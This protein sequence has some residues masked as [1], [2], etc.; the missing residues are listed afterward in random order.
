M[1]RQANE[2]PRQAKKLFTAITNTKY[3]FIPLYS[4][5]IV[6]FFLNDRFVSTFLSSSLLCIS[7][8]GAE[9]T[10]DVN[11]IRLLQSPCSTITQFSPCIS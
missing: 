7:V 1:G 5:A 11:I 3:L 8:S 6:L 2:N 9:V 4:I 10:N